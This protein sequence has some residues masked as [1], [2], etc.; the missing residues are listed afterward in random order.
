MDDQT[1]PQNQAASTKPAQATQPT[2]PTVQPQPAVG[3]TP[4]VTPAPQPISTVQP[5]TQPPKSSKKRMIISGVIL[6]VL[7]LLGIG[8]F[9]GYNY[10]NN[11]PEKV[12][13]DALTNTMSDI[14]EKKPASTIGQLVFESKGDTPV[15]ATIAFDGKYS[16]ENSQGSA[17]LTV[18]FSGKTYNIKTSAVVFG[19]EEVYFKIE[20]LKR[21]IADIINSRPELDSYSEVIDP[22]ISKIDNRWIRITKDDLKDLGMADEQTVD[23]CSNALQNIKLSKEDKKQLKKLFKENQFIIASETLQS[24]TV[25]DESSFHYKLDFN[26]SAAENFAKQVISLKSFEGV[27]N[28]CGIDEEDIEDGFKQGSETSQRNNEPKPVVELWV[29]KNSRRPT[30]FRVSANNKEVVV[31]FDTQVKFSDQTVNIEKPSS[32]VSIKELQAEFE[33][34]VPSANSSQ[35]NVSEFETL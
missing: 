26:N 1:G 4:N 29:G 31:D 33:K 8:A 5:V 19:E 6:A 9:L 27:K 22:L 34:L 3:G 17:E 23:K 12:L 2:E 10:L 32:S 35:S 14:V 28:D 11:K 30:K 18:D 15:K 24:E 25:A 20:N 16:G 21:T 13:A 7:L